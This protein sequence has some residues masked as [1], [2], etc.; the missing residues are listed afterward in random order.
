MARET[1]GGRQG[2]EVSGEEAAGAGEPPPLNLGITPRFLGSG[3]LKSAIRGFSSGGVQIPSLF[4]WFGTHRGPTVKDSR[5][6]HV[7]YKCV[8][9]MPCFY[10]NTGAEV[11]QQVRPAASPRGRSRRRSSQKL[12]PSRAATCRFFPARIDFK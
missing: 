11:A 9:A 1:L 3:R 7:H 12:S 6:F 10:L 8:P 4:T 2:K 5:W